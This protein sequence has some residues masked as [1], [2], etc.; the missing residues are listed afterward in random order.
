MQII[1][2]SVLRVGLIAGDES[3]ADQIWNG[4]KHP[5]GILFIVQYF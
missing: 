3:Y 2:D 4:N 5:A 1:K